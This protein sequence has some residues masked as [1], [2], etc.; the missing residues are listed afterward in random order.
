MREKTP[1]VDRLEVLDETKVDEIPGRLTPRVQ[2]EAAGKLAASIQN[3][4]FQIFLDK[5]NDWGSTVR[6]L[7]FVSV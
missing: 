1:D 3:G 4:A 2:R 5:G 7:R 6:Y